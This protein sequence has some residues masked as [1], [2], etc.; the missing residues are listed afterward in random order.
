MPRKPA[1]S[2][3]PSAYGRALGRL[4]RRDHAEVEMRRALKRAGHGEDEVEAAVT[5]LKG[6]R[7]LDDERFAEAFARS[8][9]LHRGLGRRRIESELQRR[10][11]TRA[12]AQ[13]GLGEALQDVSE[14]AALEAQ[15]RRYWQARTKDEPRARVQKLWAFL[16]RRGYPS[17]LV[18][19][20]LRALWPRWSDALDGLEPLEDES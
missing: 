9:L 16:L 13:K 10:G 3:A 17:D 6:Q 14:G 19:A 8:R 12:V 1:A 20:R 4:A 15:A 7:A 11:V 2:P 5:R 18:R